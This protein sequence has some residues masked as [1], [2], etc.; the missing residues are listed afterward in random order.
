VEELE[1]SNQPHKWT[2]EELTVIRDTYKAKLK[3][4]KK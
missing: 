3:E 4:L 1:A 2:R